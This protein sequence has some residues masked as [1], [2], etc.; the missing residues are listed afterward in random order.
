MADPQDY[1]IDPGGARPSVPPAK[2]RA[3]WLPWALGAAGLLVLAAVGGYVLLR[4][5]AGPPADAGATPPAPVAAS[6][7]PVD[8]EPLEPLTLPPLDETDAIVRQMVAQL[9]AHPAVAAWL[10]TDQL[11]RNFTLVVLNL[12]EGRMPAQQL[13]ALAP[14]E[15]FRVLESNGRIVIDARSYTR[16]DALAV[17]VSGLDARGT[18]RLYATL[19]PRILDAAREVGYTSEDFDPVLERT[20]VELLRAPIVE[21]DVELRQKIVSYAFADPTLEALSP[22]QRQL[23]RM[24]PRN[25]R[26]VQAK[27]REIALALGIPSTRLPP[28]R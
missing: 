18:A 4:P 7:A 3:T 13:R 10:A 26:T 22:A 21:G 6:A 11:I 1:D 20:L 19:E 16:Y 17:A 9:S 12:A 27:L 2:P 25:V 14:A 15:T 28:P 8:V 23:L 5:G 24:G